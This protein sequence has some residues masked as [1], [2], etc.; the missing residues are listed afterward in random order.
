MALKFISSSEIRQE[1]FVEFSQAMRRNDNLQYMNI[2]MEFNLLV[3]WK[4]EL[5]LQVGKDLLAVHSTN[6]K[7]ER[8]RV[9][10]WEIRRRSSGSLKTKMQIWKFIAIWFL[11]FPS[12]PLCHPD[13]LSFSFVY[14][15]INKKMRYKRTT[16]RR[17]K[18]PVSA[19]LVQ[20]LLSPSCFVSFCSKYSQQATTHT[21]FLHSRFFGCSA[22]PRTA[23]V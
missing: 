8:L 13:F 23:V 21:H 2:N 3:S 7:K 16:K 10:E 12:C 17:M 1:E 5:G 4:K 19:Q 18:N 15:S 20:E 22:Q 11:T 6:W 14:F 9:G